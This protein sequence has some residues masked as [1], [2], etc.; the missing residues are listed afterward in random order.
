M[1]AA[2][3]LKFFK[4]ARWALGLVSAAILMLPSASVAL[5][6]TYTL[7]YYYSDA[8]HT[9]Q[10][11]AGEYTCF[12][13]NWEGVK[14]SYAQVIMTEDCPHLADPDEDPCTRIPYFCQ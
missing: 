3:T 9:V 5:P 4:S 7:V 10:V 14:S 2:M 13:W 6:P 11:G 12:S 1:E 8:S